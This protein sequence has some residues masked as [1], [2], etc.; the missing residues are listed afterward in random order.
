MNPRILPILFGFFI[1]GFCDLVGISSNYVKHD[2]GC[3][4]TTAN[5]LPFMVFIWFFVFSVP[6]GIIMNKFG[7]KRTV[8][9]SNAIT[10]AA[11]LIPF[12]GY[13][14]TSCLVAFALLGIANTILQVSLNPLLSNVVN[15]QHLTSALTVGQFVKAISSLSGPFAASFAVVYFGE[16]RYIFPLFAGITL[17]SAIWLQCTRIVETE[18]AASSSSF[19]EVLGL[20]GNK[21][22]LLMF[23]C[24]I[25]LVG[26]DVG[27]NT[28]TPR[29]LVE[30]CGLNIEEAN[31]GTGVY[32]ACRTAGAFIGSFI[33]AKFSST[34][35]FR[36][37]MAITLISLIVLLFSDDRIAILASVGVIGFA[38]ASLFSII[39]SAALQKIPGKANEVSG[40]MIT[41]VSGGAL[42]PILMGLATDAAG[43]QTGSVIVIIAC[44]IYLATFGIMFND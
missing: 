42:I 20:L 35:F 12:A 18:S 3:S 36:F 9:I 4:D 13:T 22:L 15:G 23:L 6:T 16:W 25:A 14:Y 32:F 29:I 40:L 38:C 8:Q 43:N 19:K 10:L 39:F 44:A 41:G 2:F 26:L 37:S 33:L 21:T 24:I 28:A 11:M 17:L 1:M 34:K 7:R 5:F 31:Y 30:R 27:M